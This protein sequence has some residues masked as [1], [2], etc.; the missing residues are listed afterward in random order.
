MSKHRNYTKT[1]T[2]MVAGFLAILIFIVF[3]VNSL[4]RNENPNS[5]QTA[6]TI[7]KT[8]IPITEL[9]YYITDEMSVFAGLEPSY[10]Q[11]GYNL[12]KSNYDDHRT[13]AEYILE[14]SIEKAIQNNILYLEAKKANITLTDD[15]ISAYKN[16]AAQVY[17][18]LTQNQIE[19]YFLTTSNL[20]DTLAK[21][22]LADK[23]H[24]QIIKD[25]N[26]DEAAIKA[27]VSLSD[28]HQY[29]Y[30]YLLYPF[31]S[32]DNSGPDVKNFI[33]DSQKADAL[34][35][36]NEIRDSL[37]KI[38]DMKAIAIQKQV[39][40][41]KDSTVLVGDGSVDKKIEDQLMNLSTNDF[42]D[43]FETEAGYYI[44]RKLG[45][46]SKMA[47]VD[48]VN[49]AIDDAKEEA[50]QNVYQPISESYKV[51][52]HDTTLNTIEIGQ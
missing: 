45:D 11:N 21:K 17:Q 31:G 10:Q 4:N 12:W 20:Q 47:Y 50:F 49:K 2:Y 27:T 25:A 13:I 26:I 42:S 18:N 28:I 23:Y 52:K 36:M 34:K 22:A 3:L 24:D 51:T 33:S 8:K 43:V 44:V 6:I 5:K 14:T 40:I 15:E 1:F 29:K 39:I 7:G 19:N 32:P 9:N 30:D 48:A 38:Q 16:E 41:Y 46:T 37:P 35:L